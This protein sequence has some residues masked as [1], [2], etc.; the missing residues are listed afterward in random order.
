MKITFQDLEEKITEVRY[1][2]WDTLTICVVEVENGYKVVGTSAC[3]VPSEYDADLGAAIAYKDAVGKLWPLEGYLLK[4]DLFDL[5][6]VEP[7]CSDAMQTEPGD[8]EPNQAL[9][10]ETEPKLEQVP[11]DWDEFLKPLDSK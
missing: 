11:F 3:A 1:F 2:R 6:Y 4:Q 8:G 7:D 5:E 10:P 9:P